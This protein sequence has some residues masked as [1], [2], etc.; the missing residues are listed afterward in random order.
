[1]KKTLKNM[2]L[3]CLIASIAFT[4]SACGTAQSADHMD[5][6]INGVKLRLELERA[7][8]NDMG[9][10]HADYRGE[11]DNTC[12][13][14]G[15]SFSNRFKAQTTYTDTNC[16]SDTE[17]LFC[18]HVYISDKLHTN[19][20]TSYFATKLSNYVTLNRNRV[21]R[22]NASSVDQ[23]QGSF[24]FTLTGV[25]QAAGKYTGTISATAEAFEGDVERGS[26]YYGN[27][28]TVSNAAF[29]FS[30]PK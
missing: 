12:Y 4:L 23:S 17:N 11:K 9:E 30:L 24:A 18:L 8:V 26:V 25:D 19:Q 21:P 1:M 3:F 5:V 2:L 10:I 15:I 20:H 14:V 6:T 28:I 29:S 7:W 22:S 13:S 16:N 27:R